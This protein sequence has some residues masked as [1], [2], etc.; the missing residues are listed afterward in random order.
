MGELER[1]FHETWLGM[2]QPIEGLVLSVPV[3]VDAQ[4]AE[5]LPRAAHAAFLDL[6]TGEGR[7]R[8]I[9]HLPTFFER[10]LDLPPDRFATT[11]PDDVSLYVPEGKQ[12]L[13]PSAALLARPGVSSAPYAALVWEVPASV[14]DLDAPETETGAWAYPAQAKFERLL[15]AARVPIGLLTNGAELRLTYAPH[16]E[17]SG[18][19]AFRVADMAETSGRP[20]FDAMVMLLGRARWFA[21]AAERQLPAL[22]AESRRRSADVTNELARQVFEALEVLL[23]GFAAAEERDGTS[24]LRAALEHEPGHLYAGLLTVLLRLVFLLYCEDR[25]LLPTDHPLFAQ[26]YSVLG[27]FADLQADAGRTP[28]TMNRRF[29][30]YPRLVALFRAVYLGVHHVPA[31]GPPLDLPPR[32]GDLFDPNAFPFLEGRELGGAAP[33]HDEAA[34]AATRVPSVCDGTVFTVLDKLLL[35]EG[36]RLSYKALDVEQIGSVYEALMGFDVVRLAHPSVRLK[37]GQRSGA[38]RLWLS[39]EEVLAAPP[40]GRVAALQGELGFEKAAATKIAG[41]AE[42]TPSAPELFTRLTTL[43]GR[44][45]EVLPAGA[46]ALQPGPERRRT[47]SHYTPRTL[48]EPIVQRT[49]AP[50]LAAMGPTP[51]SE[52]LLGL[53]VC[54]PAMGSGAFLVAACRA[55]ADELVAAWTREGKLHLLADAHDDVVNHARRLVAQRC[56][57]GVDKN[58]YA[59]QLA[60][61]SLWL[62]TMARREPFTFVDHALRHGDSLVGLGFEEVRAFHWRPAAQTEIPARILR[63]ALGEA[64]LLRQEILALAADGSASAQREKERLLLDADD[65]LSRAKLVADVCVG[66]FFAHASDRDRERERVRRLDLVARWIETDRAGDLARAAELRAE[67]DE[68]ASELRKTQTPFH[69]ML[70]F[71]EVFFDGRPDPLEGGRVTG[72]AYV[73]AFVGN[74]PFASKNAIVGEGGRAYVPWLL[75]CY[76][77]AHG[78]ADLCAYFFRRAAD[79]LG[80]HGTI[81]L[82]ATNTISQG[83]TRTTGLAALLERGHHILHA[84]RDLPWGGDA[85]VTVSIVVLGTG[86][87]ATGPRDLD[88]RVVG[89]IDSRLDEG[90][91]RANAARLERHADLF[92]MG[93]KVYGAGFFLDPEQAAPLTADPHDAQVVFPVIGG[94]DIN[95]DP[96]QRPPQFVISFAGARS[97]RLEVGLVFYGSSRSVCDRNGKEPTRP[98]RTAHTGRSTGGSTRNRGRSCT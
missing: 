2:V 96:L 17:S 18:W 37:L 6:L 48:T 3:L 60:R 77:G 81:G 23:A 66:A 14:T 55:L 61:L 52:V 74:P 12:R 29:G 59:V 95:S 67:L 79:L 56:L 51:S 90:T 89:Q 27:L 50:L 63:E 69:W 16:G 73:E 40:R 87:A 58:R 57:Y 34:R 72:R 41:L 62:V 83:D 31:H 22:L 68:L 92:F 10:V 46:L 19:L 71:P 13:V 86:S 88:G 20:I 44:H 82:V 21:V 47:S 7:G 4:C 15:R 11:L 38:A 49:L 65:A 64:I 25:A 54:D 80:A 28:D 42:E 70:E 98:P 78:N 33:I 94:E 39:A 26:H 35:L 53:V 76:P 84:Q 32:R 85:A 1:N 45:P 75:N 36:Q 24:H 93:T 8:R 97:R 5:K 9:A 91:E 43:A 30:A